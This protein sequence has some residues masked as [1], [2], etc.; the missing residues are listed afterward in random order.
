MKKGSQGP[1]AGGS[2]S[3]C[4]GPWR[5][6]NSH[7]A[8]RGGGLRRHR[9]TLVLAAVL[10]PW[11]PTWADPSAGVTV[12]GTAI[13]STTLEV[14]VPAVVVYGLGYRDPV[15]GQ[16]PSL[17]EAEG[18]ILAVNSRRLLLASEESGSPQR[19][20]LAR[21]QT[22]IL[23]PTPLGPRNSD[24]A[25]PVEA[26]RAQAAEVAQVE[27]P[28]EPGTVTVVPARSRVDGS[29]SPPR[30]GEKL[31][32]NLIDADG[33]VSDSRWKWERERWPGDWQAVHLESGPSSK[34]T[35]K[36]EDVGHP[37][38]VR[39]SYLDAASRDGN[40]RKT[41]TSGR[42]AVPEGRGIAG[43][44]GR[45]LLWGVLGGSVI[46]TPG[47]V[48]GTVLDTGCD[49]FDSPGDLCLE[50]GG[51]IGLGAGWILGVPIGVSLQESNDRFI[52]ALGGSLGGLTVGAYLTMVD[53][54]LWPSMIWAPVASTAIA[55][56]LSRR[57]ELSRKM[58]GA[59][60]Q[61]R[62]FY[63]G[64]ALGPRGEPAAVAALWF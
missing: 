29:Q 54:A 10:G 64:P 12:A 44:V 39:V 62:R 4:A 11:D 41:A 47:V 48:I 42:L 23:R 31:V 20:D 27:A 18:V 24:P 40:D 58:L 22:V 19:I 5:Q 2:E 9:L 34:Y 15:T 28:D 52:H 55:S 56:E 21:I 49:S 14:G 30:E 63:V 36:A 60:G 35:P 13:D 33:G 45:K 32:A 43:R 6:H 46:G 16:W 51:I 1:G 50:L 59:P 53:E 3:S 37:L 57:A 61:G 38:R 25:S 7:C 26:A 8:T 17:K